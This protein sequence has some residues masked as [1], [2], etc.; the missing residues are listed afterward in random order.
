MEAKVKAVVM[1]DLEDVTRDSHIHI[2]ISNKF[3]VDALENGDSGI[4][5]DLQNKYVSFN[6]V[7]KKGFTHMLYVKNNRRPFNF[8]VWISDADKSYYVIRP[9]EEVAA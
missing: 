9:K 2:Y 7:L 6:K 1:V 3:E 8:T 5:N 4:L